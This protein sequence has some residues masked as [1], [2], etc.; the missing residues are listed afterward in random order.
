MIRRVL[1]RLSADHAQTTAEYALIL[2]FVA[3]L[4]V[5]SFA[6]FDP[7]IQGVFGIVL[8]R[9]TGVTLP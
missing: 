4:T 8:N 3:V 2:T 6:A 5:A 1:A 7:S 9:L